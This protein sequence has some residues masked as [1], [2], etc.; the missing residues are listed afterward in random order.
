MNCPSVPENV[1]HALIRAGSQGEDTVTAVSKLLG[2]LA[3][4][5]PMLTKPSVY[6]IT[7]LATHEQSSVSIFITDPVA[8]I[9]RPTRSE[10]KW[11]VYCRYISCAVRSSFEI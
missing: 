4:W 9:V 7:C 8:A 3:M 2:E 6:S 5:R 1:I 10:T 11:K